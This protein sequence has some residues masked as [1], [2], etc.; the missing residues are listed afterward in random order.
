M[1][2]ATLWLFSLAWVA[3]GQASAG[4]SLLGAWDAAD[5]P[6][7][8]LHVEPSGSRVQASGPDV[9]CKEVGKQNS[10]QRCSFIQ[11]NPDCRMDG[12]FLNY[13]NGV[14]CVFPA[15]LQPLVV[16]LYAL[17]LL[18]LFVI[19]GVTAEKFFCPN[20]SAIST[21]LKL[22]H[23]V[24]GVTFLAFGN[25]APDVFSA[26]VA[27]SDPRTAGLAIG[28]LFGAGIFVTTI[29][30]GGIALVRP[31]T[32]AS[33]PFLRDAVFY[34]VSV[35]LTFVALYFEKVSL[36]EALSYLCLYIFY[37][38]TVVV[39][40]WL[41]KRQRRERLAPPSPAEPDLGTDSEDGDSSSVDYREEYR[42]LLPSQEESTRQ[43]LAS[44]LNPLDH[45]KW[46][47]KPCCWRLLKATQL[48]VELVLL[49]TV[50]VVDPDRED[51]NWKRPLNC[52]HLATGPL[53]CVLALKSGSYGFY[54]IQGAF[55]VWGLVVLGG[56]ALALV[57]FCMTRN[58]EPPRFHFVF[59]FL[60]FLVSAMWIN[61]AATEV[62]NILRTLGVV[63]S[64]SNTV[65]G[66]TLL[67]WGN[68]IGDMFSDLTMARQGY[69]RMAFSACFGGIIFNMLVGVG[70]GCLLQMTSG[71]LA[72]KLDPA[73]LLVWVLAGALGLSLVFS[74]L[75]VPAQR[76]QLGRG[77]GCCLIAYYLVFLTV[78]LLTEFRVIRIS[79][80]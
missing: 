21:T 10:T 39:S 25:G 23:N 47:R 67:A 42:P 63:F 11:N 55:P 64:L 24:A 6:G 41:H 5:T 32:A 13:L 79:T 48:P 38:A 68:S 22:A 36:A 19:L 51:R 31:F 8:A 72:V 56:A 80:F 49:L 73:G 53:V 20:L 3:A 14:F 71:K 34:M 54:K 44:A 74:F 27:F 52:L 62:V 61:A 50:P 77:Y 2:S 29:V 28:A 4:G 78:A 65:L 1:A 66:L 33:R 7:S 35:F 59:A 18:Y 17:W 69:P 40:T 26:V 76:F 9:D 58:E 45:R 37:V 12:G 46:R 43:L 16:T 57:V 75:S 15:A 30:A 60:G 70:L